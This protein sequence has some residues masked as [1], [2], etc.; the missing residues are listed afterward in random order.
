MSP[1][2]ADRTLCA[3]D[4][5]KRVERDVQQTG[6]WS[7]S[8]VACYRVPAVSPIKRLSHTVP[9]D[10]RLSDRL[11]AVA[12]RGEFAPLSFV[13]FPFEDVERFELA[14]SDLEGTGGV[15]PASAIDIRVVKCWYQAGTAWYSYF[16][17]SSRRVLV[18]ELLLHDD[19]LV[20]VDHETKDNYLRIDYPE[21]SEYV[22]VSYPPEQ[23]SGERFNY[24]TEPVF[25]TPD[26]KPVS[27]QRGVARQFWVTV[28]VPADAH[29]GR[30]EC[31]LGLACGGLGEVAAEHPVHT[32]S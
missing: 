21:G 14:V 18:P 6:V 8:P 12:A 2:P 29:A 23:E 31:R 5:A 9:P 4:N 10:G 15:V 26:L 1:V 11:R 19:T 28:H 3:E 27:L 32:L 16:A 24:C 25:D 17:D 22:C 30:Y 7:G 13:V 20:K